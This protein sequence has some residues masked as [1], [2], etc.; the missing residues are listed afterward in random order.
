MNDSRPHSM[1]KRSRL[2]NSVSRLRLAAGVAALVGAFAA[3]VTMASCS[4]EDGLRPRGNSNGQG[5]GSTSSGVGTSS[6]DVEPNAPCTSGTTA[7][8]HVT[9]GTNGDVLT[10]LHGER[11]CVGGSWGPCVGQ[12]ESKSMPP[13][14]KPV[15][16]EPGE[17]RAFGLSDAGPCQN[18]PCD[19]YCQDYE[20]VPGADAGYQVVPTITT[21][22]QTGSFD[23]Y[24][25]NIPPGFVDKGINF[26]CSPVN[27]VTQDCEFDSRCLANGTNGRQCVD[28]GT[29]YASCCMPWNPDEYQNCNPVRPDFSAGLA[30]VMS[31]GKKVVPICNRGNQAVPTGAVIRMHIWGGNAPS[32]PTCLPNKAADN[33]LHTLTQP[34][35]PGKC[36]NADCSAFLPGNGNR[37]I[38]VNGPT[39]SNGQFAGNP[40]F[41]AE[42][43]CDNNWTVWKGSNNNPCQPVQVY[44]ANPIV[45]NLT[46]Q[47]IC[48][49]GTRVQ[50]QYL[51]WDTTT[52]GNSNVVWAARV[53]ATNAGLSAANYFALGTAKATPLPNTQICSAAG[54]AGCPINLFTTF[55]DPAAYNEFLEL[56]ITMNPTSDLKAGSKVNNWQISYTCPPSQ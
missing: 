45:K 16:W 17:Y 38:M 40:N 51:T 21:V 5:G 10:C 29:T 43:T 24:L 32:F 50:W 12:F 37:T 6:G 22:W 48:P 1:A 2:T 28:K 49:V 9:M 46:Y 26:P 13:N 53:A 31:D 8:C 36:V 23:D 55:G 11:T 35:E 56:R 20:E 19:P 14:E 33:C 3:A 47:G 34:L 39:A 15:D 7:E 52:P 27:S 30:C 41:R 18:N 54:P 42:C 25:E 44:Q 4:A